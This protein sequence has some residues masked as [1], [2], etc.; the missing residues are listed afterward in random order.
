MLETI[1][2]YPRDILESFVNYPITTSLCVI[3]GAPVIYFLWA[4]F[5]YSLVDEEEN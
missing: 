3:L 1:I 2:N 4:Y 5:N